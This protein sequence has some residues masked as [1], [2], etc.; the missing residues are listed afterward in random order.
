MSV[1]PPE[2]EGAPTPRSVA[3]TLGL[4]ALSAGLAALLSVPA[5]FLTGPAVAITIAS[6][7]GLVTA[8]PRRLRDGCFVVI[9]V[10]M[11][12]GVT[13][14]AVDQLAAWPGS[15]V[16]LVLALGAICW[17]GAAC[18]SGW[19]GYT[20][21]AALMG[22]LPG[23]LSYVLSI[24]ERYRGADV[25]AMAVV[26]SLR[27]LALTLFVPVL[28][29]A[30]TGADLSGVPDLGRDL[31]PGPLALMIALTAGF[32]VFLGRMGVPAAFIV[33]GLALSGTAHGTGLVAGDLPPWLAWPAFVT[34]GTLIGS[35]FSGV[36]PARLG[37]AL[38]AGAAVTLSASAI[39]ALAAFATATALGLPFTQVLIAFAP[40]ALETMAA[41][42]IL[43][44]SDT[45]YVAAHHAA[46][47]VILTIALPLL[48]ART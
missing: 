34:M 32:G 4:G 36:T 29:L 5:P 43:T 27:V 21:P 31:A 37:R 33:A 17:A 47:M 7:A 44:Q 22:A 14:E 26:Q 20:R 38:A 6:V 10:G 11:G 12:A 42:A 48:L 3:L 18:L 16:A 41:L 24:A 46:R 2:P 35:R 8:L 23:H 30:S 45:A 19:F 15:F 25:D 13:P 9:G 39:A 1:E 28:I 40:G